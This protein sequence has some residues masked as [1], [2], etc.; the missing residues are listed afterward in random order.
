[1]SAD[2]DTPGTYD[3][4][5]ADGTVWQFR[6]DQFAQF[7]EARSREDRERL[8]GE[9]WT[10]LD[11]RIEPGETPPHKSAVKQAFLETVTPP[12]SASNVTVYVLGK[13]KPGEEGLK[14]V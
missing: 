10:P 11:E 7:T 5:A 1:M 4:L 9:G 13:L 3:V 2:Y 6:A 12:E 14:I 8:I